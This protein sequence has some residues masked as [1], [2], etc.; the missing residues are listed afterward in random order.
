MV[1]VNRRNAALISINL[2]KKVLSSLLILIT[3]L[4]AVWSGLLPTEPAAAQAVSRPKLVLMLVAD[5]FAFNY[6]ARYQDKFSSGGLRFLMDNG[7]NFTNC[8]YR[9]A[10]T[11]S[12]CGHAVI[13]T[14]AYPWANG[15]IGDD[16]Y[17]LRKAKTQSIVA[18][19]CQLVGGNGPAGGTKLLLGTTLG[20]QFKLASNG[21]SKVITASMD[22]RSSLLLAGR[23]AN[24]GYWYDTKTG[25]FVTSSQYG[26]D[27]PAWV[28]SFNDQHYADKYMGKPWQRVMPETQYGAST[29]DDY[30]HERSIPQ[31]GRQ[32]PHVIAGGVTPGAEGGG[33]YDNFAMT[34]WANQMLCD[35]TR[36][37]IEKENLGSHSDPDFMAVSF[38]PLGKLGN[39]FG[40][41]SQEVEDSV[42]RLDQSLSTLF[43]YIDQKLN[44]NNCLIVFTSNHGSLP[45][46]EF[47]REKGFE[48]GRIDPNGLKAHVDGQLDA[49][50]GAQDWVEAFEP[51]NLY[52]NP[53]AIDKA[54]V[55]H[56]EVQDRA[57]K[58]A[59]SFSGVGDVYTEIEFVVNQAHNG[60]YLDPVR[61]SYYKGRSGQ[62][63]VVP[64]PGYIFSGEANGTS[65]GSP[66]AYD[67]QVPL[68]F[69]GL[70]VQP[71]RYA[72]Q[73]SPADIAPTI[74][75]I[76]GSGE[77][78]LSEGRALSE[79]VAQFAGPPS[80]R[81]PFTPPATTSTTTK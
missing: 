31:D 67:S 73:A 43:Q 28:K 1:T 39:A 2:R 30:P 4:S 74:S 10:N 71:G 72:V 12:A 32:F 78:S 24:G 23:L 3:V 17:S 42:I 22:D 27:L 46:P 48:A 69:V 49:A 62:L 37:A 47:L 79:A 53:D 65:S 33:F 64:K 70:G 36:E 58:I 45:I 20:D 29:R 11:Q 38:T 6:L 14:G 50:F 13:S 40:P 60:P 5:Q 7:A 51:P 35:F 15:I 68:I 8:R 57:S 21:R 80:P 66:Y 81:V 19:D 76:A 75:A 77:P 25:V 44:L 59:K 18:D 9:Q 26:R 54:K 41:Y 56:P 55:S 16:W 63:Y 61:T 52:L 34:P